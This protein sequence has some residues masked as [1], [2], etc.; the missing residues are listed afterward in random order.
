[1]T[2][3]T[4]PH[5]VRSRINGLVIRTAALAALAAF[6]ASIIVACAKAPA[7]PAPG[8]RVLGVEELVRLDLLPR[9]KQSVEVGCVSSWDRT[10]GNDD[11]FSGKYSFLR[12]EPGG[13][14]LADL[15]GPGVIYRI[16]T[17]TPTDETIEF[18][19]DGEPA[20]RISLKVT[21]VFDG[22]H[23]PFLAPL[24]GAGAG[25]RYSYVPLTYCKSCKILVKAEAFR[26]IQINY[27]RFAPDAN[28][29]TFENPPG[30][31]FL[32]AVDEAARL[33]AS[34]GSD[35]SPSLVPE[36]TRLE[37]K[38]VRAELPPGGAVTLLESSKPGRVVGLRVG[39]AFALAGKDRDILIRMTWEGDVEPAVLCP[40]GDFFGASFG[41]P[42]VRSLLLGTT[43]D[44]DYVYFPMPYERSALIELVS[45]R[46]AGPPV[47]VRSE[48]TFAPLGKAE[49]EGR[50]YARWHRENPTREGV[51]FTY[52]RTTGRGHV[53]GMI[54]QAQ[55][56]TPGQ[57]PF[58]EGDDRAVIDGA[59][60]IPGTGSEDSFNGGWYDVPGRWE[61][62]GSRP[63]S[64]CLDYEKPLGR[65]GGYR[66][67]VTD[68]YAY[69]QS[70]DYTIEHGPEGNLTPTD[71]AAVVFFYSAAPP[72]AGD[73][74][75]PV[76]ARKVSDPRKIVFVP[77]W[78]VPIHSSS[79]QNAVLEKTSEQVGDSRVRYLSVRTSGEDVFGPHHVSFICDI[80]AAGKYAVGLKAVKGPGQ[81]IVQLYR[82]DLPAGEPVNL[83]AE[84]RSVSELL[85]M[86]TFD[87]EAGE[88]LLFLTLVGRDPRTR[89]LGMDLVEIVLDRLD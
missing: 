24:V 77:G 3:G 16:H 69:A 39:P 40:A 51:P 53:V 73:S 64:G 46:S 74:L 27:A 29:P 5:P 75:P 21:E 49:D 35:I 11:G 57:T 13:L 34:T 31:G 41:E 78:N 25:G 8:P 37:K 15:R 20:P 38:V 76:A 71:Y 87:L 70:I 88:N 62:R 61:S 83:Y 43:G 30:P 89:G 68:S 72:P 33:F 28:I 45:E 22:R 79:L 48:V 44:D 60:A 55:G 36:G 80:P 66:W 65:T 52:L 9:L 54:L 47:E 23:S 86:G 7:P 19:F 1:M 84:A 2:R 82:N 17:P 58:F 63:L 67:L 81:A 85:P 50:F 32:R 14:V 26:F 18:Y 12:R 4:R 10:G 56:L 42:A 59:P 6:L